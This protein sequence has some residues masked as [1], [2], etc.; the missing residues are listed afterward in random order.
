MSKEMI[1]VL[2]NDS[3]LCKLIP[4]GNNQWEMFKVIGEALIISTYDV[5]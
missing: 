4:K 5:K 3:N 1:G 2:I